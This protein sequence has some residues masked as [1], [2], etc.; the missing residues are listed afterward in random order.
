MTENRQEKTLIASHPGGIKL[1]KHLLALAEETLELYDEDL[2]NAKI[3]KAETCSEN[4]ENIDSNHKALRVL[5]LGAG[6]G[7]SAAYLKSCGWDAVGIDLEF[8]EKSESVLQ[9]DMRHLKFAAG[10][11]DLC[12]AECSLSGCGDGAQALAES[13]RVLKKEGLLLVSD[14][15]FKKPDA[16]TLSMGGP[17]TKERWLL[18]FARAGFSLCA[19]QDETP[20]WREFFLESLWNGN[21][22]ETCVELFSRYGKAKCGYFLA[23]LK[24]EA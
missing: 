22:D 1:T 5:D 23:V 7:E 14:V 6:K 9:M 8:M 3:R 10:S 21:A 18:E 2:E 16:P 19:W 20:L 12:L 13:S 17:L 4:F 24:K 11:F 15:F